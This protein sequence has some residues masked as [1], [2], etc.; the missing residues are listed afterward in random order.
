MKKIYKDC[1]KFLKECKIHILIILVL[2]FVSALVGFLFPVFFVD[3]IKKFIEDVVSKTEGL[4]F[5]QLFL[6]IAQNNIQTAFTGVILGLILGIVPLIFALFNGYV[7]GFVAR[8]SVEAAGASVLLRLL[9][10]GIF[11]LPALV[12]SLA[13]GLKLGVSVFSGKNKKNGFVY[14][15]KNSLK[16]FFFIILPLLLIAALIEAGLIFLIK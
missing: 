6:F 8:G 13:L 1:W 4:G 3:F 5:W 2:F 7:L 10:H 16:V 12:L 9:P 11:E 15:F 14:N